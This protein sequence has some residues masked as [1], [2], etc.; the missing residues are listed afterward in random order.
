MNQYKYIQDL[1]ELAGL[2]GSHPIDT[3]MGS[4]VKYHR[5]E[6]KLLENPTLYR[7]LVG[8]LIYLTIP[9]LDISF[10][11][12]TVST[13][14]HSPRQIHLSAVKCIIRSILETLNHCLLFSIGSSL[15]LQAYSDVD[16]GG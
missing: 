12:H 4:N 10:V 11:V 14:M 5:N 8:Y 3:Q 16:W 2:T 1:V 15:Q 7:K 6:R 9:R 13:F